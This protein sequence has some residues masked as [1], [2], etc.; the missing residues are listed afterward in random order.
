MES[1]ED[2]FLG[3]RG[4]ELLFCVVLAVTVIF[5]SF[6]PEDMFLMGA[7]KIEGLGRVEGA[8]IDMGSAQAAGDGS[9]CLAGDA[10]DGGCG[11]ESNH[12]GIIP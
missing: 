1:P 3:L 2:E 4:S 8:V 7:S 5:D 11:C 10:V 6:P 12:A 9:G